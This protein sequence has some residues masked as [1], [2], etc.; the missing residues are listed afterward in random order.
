MLILILRF[1]LTFLFYKGK[2]RIKNKFWRPSIVI[3]YQKVS[4][5]N[6]KTSLS[7]PYTNLQN[8]VNDKKEMC[9]LKKETYTLKKIQFYFYNSLSCDIL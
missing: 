3:S 4:I 5:K 6:L 2:L 8:E 9:Q 7:K 1:L